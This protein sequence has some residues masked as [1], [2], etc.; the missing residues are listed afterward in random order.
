MS[1]DLLFIVIFSG[2][3]SLIIGLVSYVIC[4]IYGGAR[5]EKLLTKAIVENSGNVINDLN[6]DCLTVEEKAR[7]LV[8]YL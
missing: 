6:N 7:R 2:L 4:I 1:V 5:C 8:A 3:G